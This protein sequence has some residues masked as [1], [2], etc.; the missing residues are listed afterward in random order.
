MPLRSGAA[1]KRS[2]S[3]KRR[4]VGHVRRA[5]QIT[6]FGVGS[7]VAIE[8]QSFIVGGLDLWKDDRTL[9][10]D[11]PRLQRRLRVEG[12]RLPPSDVPPSGEGVTVRRFPEWYSCGNCGDI[13]E[14]RKFG[15]ADTNKCNVCKTV[16]TPSR[17]I[18]A[19]AGGHIDDFPYW[20]WVHHGAGAEAE[21][22]RGGAL[23]LRSTGQSAALRSIVI[24]C[25]CGRESTMEGAFGAAALSSL[26]IRCTARKPWLGPGALDPGCDETPRT[27]Q[28]GSSATWF[29]IVRSALSIPPFSER[30]QTL[31]APHFWMWAD[32]D[33]A[34]IRRQAARLPHFAEAGYSPDEVLKGVRHREELT[35]EGEAQVEEAP[36]VFEASH[37]LR[38]EE[39]RKLCSTVPESAENSQFVCVPPD[40]TGSQGPPAGIGRTMLVTRLREVR[41]LTGFVR[42]DLPLPTD[43]PARTAR[44]ASNAVQ[45]LPAVEV[46]G[47]GV[48]LRLDSDLLRAWE[49]RPEVVERAA[50]V[51]R[52]HEASLRRRYPDREVPSPVSPRYLLVHTLAHVLINEWSL[53]AG[54]SASALCERLYVD[55]DEMAGLLIYTATSDSAG[56]LGGVI[57][58]GAPDRLDRTLRSA[59]RRASWCSAD[60]LCIESEATG[61]ESLNLAACHA[62][63][64]LP[65]TSCEMNNT[66]LDRAML[67]GSRDRPTLGYF[68]TA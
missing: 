23:K 31:I 26:G 58:Q 41:A 33:D 11:E 49:L 62:C 28:R 25:S 32:E 13:Q 56:S 59:L 51:R 47:E 64:L 30:L 63:V 39:F 45:W 38:R 46:S 14:Y 55:D 19:C 53:D 16:L 67:I 36:G 17:F 48:F 2:G 24:N 1:V 12:F 60:P 6:T 40:V 5:Q 66:V 68:E 43:S 61:T 3:P 34:V 29:P 15:A 27:M 8:D 10:L 57:A 50:V 52:R 21:P 37:E 9:I 7:L 65:E 18:V 44:L 54:Y 20:R 4:P 42:V 22:C 35:R